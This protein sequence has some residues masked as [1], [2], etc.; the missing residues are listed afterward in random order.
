MVIAAKTF[1]LDAIDM[2]SLVE[3]PTGLRPANSVA[4]V[5]ELQGQRVLERGMPRWKAT[6]LH[7]QGASVLYVMDVFFTPISSKQSTHRRL[8]SYSQ[9]SYQPLEVPVFLLYCKHASMIFTFI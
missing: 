5:C 4:G 2:V 1:G 3:I 7:W 6:R 9:P 8:T